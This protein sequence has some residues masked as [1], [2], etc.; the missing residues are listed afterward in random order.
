MTPVVISPNIIVPETKQKE[1][2]N[3]IA[4]IELDKYIRKISKGV[5][6]CLK[7]D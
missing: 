2:A 4:K 5:Q 3:S 6:L 7:L 1:I